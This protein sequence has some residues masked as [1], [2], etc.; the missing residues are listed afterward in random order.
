M[1]PCWGA[2]LPP[3]CPR[4]RSHQ[5]WLRAAQT[6]GQMEAKTQLLQLLLL[7]H[8]AQSSPAHGYQRE[9]STGH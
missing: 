1:T 3:R 4:S 5:G 8:A 2:A 7:M 6:P 9:Q